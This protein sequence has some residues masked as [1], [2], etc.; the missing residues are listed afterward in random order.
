MF[1]PHGAIQLALAS[2]HGGLFSSYTGYSGTYYGPAARFTRG[3]PA[4]FNML[5]ALQGFG[6]ACPAPTITGAF[7][8]TQMFRG[9]AS[10]IGIIGPGPASLTGGG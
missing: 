4:V 1:L 3:Q 10:A 2:P 7:P 5:S 9:T 6:S 8:A